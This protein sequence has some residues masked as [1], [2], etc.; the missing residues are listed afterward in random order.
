LARNHSILTLHALKFERRRRIKGKEEIFEALSLSSKSL[1][2][3]SGK[4]TFFL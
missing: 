4:E 3:Y 1:A 2:F